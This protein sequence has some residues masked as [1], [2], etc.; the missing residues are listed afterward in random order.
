MTH[1]VKV[2]KDRDKWRVEDWKQRWV[3]LDSAENIKC[4]SQNATTYG[5]HYPYSYEHHWLKAVS[6]GR[7]NYFHAHLL[8]DNTWSLAGRCL[9][10]KRK[11]PEHQE[12]KK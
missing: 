6:E 3:Q 12:K 8:P 11:W 7:D 2:T 9:N 10:P 4:G 1:I 5:D